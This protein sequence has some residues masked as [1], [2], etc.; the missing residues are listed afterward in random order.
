MAKAIA[1]FNGGIGN[2]KQAA[3]REDGAVFE[4]GQYRDPRYGYKWSQWRFSGRKLSHNEMFGLDELF[5]LRRAT[6]PYHDGMRMD[7]SIAVR[8]PN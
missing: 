3:V 7:G 1:L 8:L 4:R 5:G 2:L 6:T